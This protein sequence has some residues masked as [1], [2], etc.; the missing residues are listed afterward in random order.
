MFD[1]L[2]FKSTVAIDVKGPSTVSPKTQSAS[3]PLGSFVEVAPS[4]PVT[5]TGLF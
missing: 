2:S 3:S 5:L 4:S 1:S